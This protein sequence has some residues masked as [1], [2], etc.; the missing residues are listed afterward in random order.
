MKRRR[1]IFAVVIFELL[2]IIAAAK[3]WIVKDPVSFDL[4]DPSLSEEALYSSLSE[5]GSGGI[6]LENPAASEY[7]NAEALKYEPAELPRG[8]YDVTIR[9]AADADNNYFVISGGE[10][11]IIDAMYA[12]DLT[13]WLS[14]S[15]GEHVCHIRCTDKTDELRLAIYY[16]G[17]GNLSVQEA[18]IT[19]T[20]ADAVWFV[21]RLVLI[22]GLIDLA[23]VFRKRILQCFSQE[24]Y[25]YAV[26]IIMLILFSSFPLFAGGIYGG[27]D[28]AFHIARIEGL[29]E[30]IL[31]GQ[32]PAKM[33]S[34]HLYGYGYATGQMYP[35]LFLYPAAFLRILGLDRV[36]AHDFLVLFIN[37]LTVLI[38][39]YSFNKIFKNRVLAFTGSVL[40]SL[41]PYRILDIYYRDALGEYCAMAGIPLVVWGIYSFVAKDREKEKP[42]Y[43]A[44][45]L[46]YTII[47]Q[48]HL[49]SI[50]FIGLYSIIFGLIFIKRIFNKER[51]SALLKMTILTVL[52]NLGFIV[53]CLDYM[54]LK[55]NQF[56]KP[57]KP[58]GIEIPQLFTN[59]MLYETTDLLSKKTAFLKGD[60]GID[61][62]L[63]YAIGYALLITS[64]I[65]ILLIRKEK[66]NR[67][68]GVIAISFGMINVI[69]SLHVFPWEYFEKNTIIAN[70]QFPWRFLMFAAIA[71]TVSGCI[72]TDYMMKRVSPLLTV[73]LVTMTAVYGFVGM[74]DFLVERV[75]LKAY[76]GEAELQSVENLGLINEYLLV[77][78]DPGLYV[79][80]GEKL[81][82]SPELVEI[83][84]YSKQGTKIQFTCKNKSDAE[85]NIELPLVMYPGYCAKDGTG[86]AIPVTYG[87][88]QLMCV[89]VPPNF[90]GTVNIWFGGKW[91]W[92]LA[93]VISLTAFIFMVLYCAWVGVRQK[94]K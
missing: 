48:S 47:L 23:L 77:D 36:Q 12:E 56:Y 64:V 34:T 69:L 4:S 17:K 39:Y 93:A 25:H 52:I 72:G 20:N 46:G 19:Q 7:E 55:M 11:Q 79:Q 51:L 74:T 66:K 65:F 76:I 71:F 13:G 73:I 57:I 44:L 54:R 8:T 68:L 60:V 67:L 90:S 85:Q 43:I 29:K 35:Q 22:L 89:V 49:L 32:F 21:I 14:S 27:N 88:N 24:N 9:Y 86:R 82:A 91:Y 33:H 83:S 3:I 42:A 38:A 10:G 59:S 30:A 18:L 28:T 84:D 2:F 26:G 45:T 75:S 41:A 70:I 81:S 15:A 92:K 78:T 63:P 61:N 50:L 87:N 5:D 16:W 1:I 62:E 80:R 94:Q 40:Y 53:P 31:S 6:V 58:H 37:C